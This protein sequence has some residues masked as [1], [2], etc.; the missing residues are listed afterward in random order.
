MKQEN[1]N[2]VYK[3]NQVHPGLRYKH[4]KSNFEL[5]NKSATKNSIKNFYLKFAFFYEKKH[6]IQQ[7]FI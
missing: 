2:R 7:F 1:N 4:K 3:K 6:I 5:K